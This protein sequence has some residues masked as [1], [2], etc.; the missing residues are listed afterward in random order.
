MGL[1]TSLGPLGWHSAL[2]INSGSKKVQDCCI[3]ERL[4]SSGDAGYLADVVSNIYHARL[5]SK[6]PLHY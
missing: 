5:T 1:G 4:D 6:M 2:N 3:V